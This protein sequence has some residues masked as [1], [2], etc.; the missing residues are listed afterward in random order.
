[1]DELSGAVETIVQPVVLSIWA[2]ESG[3]RSAPHCVKS[4]E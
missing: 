3:K 1:M 2:T 4:C